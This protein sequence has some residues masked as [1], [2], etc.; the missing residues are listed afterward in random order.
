MVETRLIE[1]L[2]EAEHGQRQRDA[3][4]A[5]L[6]AHARELHRSDGPRAR[7]PKAPLRRILGDMLVR[8]AARAGTSSP[9]APRA[10][11]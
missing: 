11:A 1:F 4:A 10:K 8:A 3:V 9:A 7:S 6:S 2:A 5:R